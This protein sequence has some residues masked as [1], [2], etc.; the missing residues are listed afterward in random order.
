MSL[1]PIKKPQR[2]SIVIWSLIAA[3]MVLVILS[4]TLRR[5]EPE[6]ESLPERSF[7]V[8]IQEVQPREV[9]HVIRIPGRMEAH[10]ISRLAVDKGGRVVEIMADKGDRVDQ[11]QALLKLDDR[12]WRTML[13][14]A[15]IELREAER[16]MRRFTEMAQTG[17]IS[18]SDVD[19]VR[20]RLDRA[21]VSKQEAQVH[22]EQCLVTSPFDGVVNDRYVEIGEFAPEGSAV[23]EVLRLDPMKLTLDIPERDI[24]AIKHGQSLV[25]EIAGLGATRMTGTVTHVASVAFPENNSFRVEATVPNPDET[26][27]AGMIASARFV[28]AHNEQAV[29][30]PLSSVIPRKGEHIVFIANKDNRAERRLVKIDRISGENV[31]L[32]SGLKAGE[33]LIVEGHRLLVDGA[34]IEHQDGE[35]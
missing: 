32:S 17:A 18:T 6:R 3:L 13:S 15:E 5:S 8:R 4:M 31:V 35:E 28:R 2:S 33:Q 24:A 29:V 9:D 11:G 27:R 12:L 1:W 34:R 21:R 30:I 7:P 23:F 14:Q 26:L 16:E 10:T 22:V 20:A 19:H 25:F